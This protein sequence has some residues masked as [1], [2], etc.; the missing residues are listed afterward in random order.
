MSYFPFQPGQQPMSSSQGVVIASNQ[1]PV[2]VTG[3]VGVGNFPTSQ[4][5]SG[6]VVAYMGGAWSSSVQGAF[7]VIGTVPVTQVGAWSTSVVGQVGASVLGTVPVVQSG[8]NI[9]SISGGVVSVVSGSTPLNIAGSVAA[10]ITASTSASV[11]T[12]WPLAS[13][14]GTYAEDATHTSADRG[15][16][17]LGVRNDAVASF[18]SANREYGPYA[19]DSAGR[20]LNKPF[21]AEEARVEGYAS[22]VS[23][24]VTTLVAAAGAGLRNYITDIQ[25]ANTG[26]SGTLVTFRSGGGTSI[27]GYSIAPTGGGSNITFQTPMRTLA[28]ETFD[29]QPSTA[30]SVLY[31]TV[32]GFK[33]P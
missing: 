8:T 17:V 29:I 23:T 2:S 27:L 26:A 1:S 25:L 31:A 14:A 13:I 28:N 19:T 5:V 9:T 3:T 15:L 18:V 22:I 10:Q 21:A 30:T 33:A 4:N 32:K 6:S 7:S 20:T 16:F 24:S 11:I 12:I